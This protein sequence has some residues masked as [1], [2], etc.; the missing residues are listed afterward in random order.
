MITNLRPNYYVSSE[1]FSLEIFSNRLAKFVYREGDHEMVVY[2]E[3]LTG[4]IPFVIYIDD[5]IK[6]WNPP[7]DAEPI[8]NEKRM[9]ILENIRK[10]F[11]FEGEE[12]AVI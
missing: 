6:R 4:S 7:H 1:G 8:T 10:I 5:E 3:M 12:I 9:Q 11:R 2:A